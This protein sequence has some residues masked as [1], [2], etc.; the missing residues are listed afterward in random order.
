MVTHMSQDVQDN[1]GNDTYL[2]PDV[3]Q[4]L[5]DNEGNDTD[6]QPDVSGLERCPRAW[7]YVVTHICNLM[8]HICKMMMVITHI[9]NLM[10]HNICKTPKT[11]M[12]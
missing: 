10:C 9:C 6:I 1:D 8:C 4:D 7:I 3:S 2:Q 11:V 12:K 5:Q